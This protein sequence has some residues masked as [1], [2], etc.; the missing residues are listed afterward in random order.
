MGSLTSFF[1]ATAALV[2]HD[3]KKVVAFSTCSQLGYMIFAC[4]TSNYFTS[5]FHL[6]NHAFFKALLFLGSGAIIHS[7]S[8]EQDIR[9]LGGL[10]QKLPFTYIMM[11]IGSIALAGIPFLSGFYSKDVI[12]ESAYSIYLFKGSFSFILGMLSAF[13]TA[14]YSMRLLYLT[15]LTKSNVFYTTLKSLHQ[16]SLPIIISLSILAIGSIFFG[17]LTRDFFVGLG[18]SYFME[19]IFIQPTSTSLLDAEFI[20]I[21]VKLLPLFSGLFGMGSAFLLFKMPVLA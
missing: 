20:P 2:Q 14:F 21:S 19:S 5:F 11:F 12:L 6:A 1:A 8:N 9:K 4:G 16:T 3:I 18:S 13:F 17:Y 15:F 10:V 7:V